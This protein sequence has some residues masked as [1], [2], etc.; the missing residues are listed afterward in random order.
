MHEH[1]VTKRLDD[2][3][4]HPVD[5]PL[6]YP[7][8]SSIADKYHTWRECDEYLTKYKEIARGGQAKAQEE[9][10]VKALLCTG[11]ALAP[12]ITNQWVQCA[13][14]QSPQHP[15]CIVLKRMLDRSL[16]VEGQALLR[17]MAPETF[18]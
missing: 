15:Q 11:R 1:I 14:R 2:R 6:A 10:Y 13:K 4:M 16:R 5:H 12:V 9:A 17:H 8:S 7:S 18:K 3:A